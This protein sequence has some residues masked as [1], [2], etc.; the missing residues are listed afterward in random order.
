MALRIAVA[1][2]LVGAVAL[3]AWRYRSSRARLTTTEPLVHGPTVP[4]AL[5]DGAERTWVLFTTPYCAACGPVEEQLRAADP[6][7]RLVKVDA[8]REVGLAGAFDVKAAPT[9]LLADGEGTVQARLVGAPAVGN[10][11]AALVDP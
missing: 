9:V 1:I 6:A 8:T 2:A 10:Y 4:A 5:L 3:A 11:V 7:A